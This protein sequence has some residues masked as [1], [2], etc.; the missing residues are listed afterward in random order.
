VTDVGK[1]VRA[2]LDVESTVA[3]SSS[4]SRGDAAARAQSQPPHLAAREIA[5]LAAGAVGEAD[6]R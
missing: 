5:D 3:S 2:R 4:N 6:A 1:D